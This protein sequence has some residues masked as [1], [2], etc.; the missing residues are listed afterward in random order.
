MGRKEEALE[1]LRDAAIRNGIDVERE[2]PQGMDLADEEKE[3]ADFRDLLSPRWRKLTLTLWAVWVGFAFCY[4]TIIMTITRIFDEEDEDNGLDFDYLAIFISSV[5]EFIGVAVA[6][7]LVDSVGRVKS[8]IVSFLI[9]GS[10]MLIVCMFNGVFS[11]MTIV[12]FSFLSRASEMAAACVT[13]IATAEL[14][15]TNMRS[16]GHAAA[17]SV[18]RFGAFLTPFLVNEGSLRTVGIALICVSVTAATFASRLP[19]TSGIELGKAIILEEE[20][21]IR[22]IESGSPSKRIWA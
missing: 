12:A 11:R 4:F 1:V 19:E 5:S 14:L 20:E 8:L 13:W 17:N 3:S 18:A 10:S 7:A 15:A 2:F 22:R 9:G 16:T 21:E 6:I